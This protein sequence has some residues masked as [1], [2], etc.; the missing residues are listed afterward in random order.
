MARGM[1]VPDDKDLQNDLRI[2]ASS[3]RSTGVH[4][5]ADEALSMAYVVSGRISSD[6]EL[7]S[8]YHLAGLL[9]ES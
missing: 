6:S 7:N 1:Q 8:I 9:P 4:N 5:T 3:D 2:L